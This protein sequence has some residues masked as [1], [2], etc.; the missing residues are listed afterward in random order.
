M[1]LSCSIV[2]Q[3]A[4]DSA[5]VTAL[6]LQKSS[7]SKYEARR[8]TKYT[9]GDERGSSGSLRS[10][11]TTALA[12]QNNPQT[13]N[14]YAT[15]SPQA[16]SGP[17]LTARDEKREEVEERRTRKEQ[18]SREKPSYEAA[19]EPPQGTFSNYCWKFLNLS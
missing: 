16:K 19:P 18:A 4:F 15:S 8:E 11:A 1:P 12:Q 5:H 17:P 3:P 13:E 2:L 7:N 6:A 9:P 10:P 14:L